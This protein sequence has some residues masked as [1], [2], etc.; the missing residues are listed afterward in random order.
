[1]PKHPIAAG[2]SEHFDIPQT[3]MYG[4]PFHVPTPDE[5]IF[6][7]KW[8]KGEHFRS[9]CVWRLGKGK[10]FYFRPGHETYRVYTQPMPLKIIVS[11]LRFI[12]ALGTVHTSSPVQAA[13]F[14]DDFT[15]ASMKAMPR[16]PSS[17]FGKSLA[18]AFFAS[19]LPASRARMA[20][21]KFL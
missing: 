4:E 11:F 14:F 8:D 20:L 16:T 13:F 19:F 7:E 15:T 18:G 1:M 6:E 17:I 10:V 2:V 3:E 21:A 9:G 5:V 12:H